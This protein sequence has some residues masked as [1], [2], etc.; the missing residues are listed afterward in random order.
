MSDKTPSAFSELFRSIK[1]AI[2]SKSGKYSL[3]TYLDIIGEF[4][5]RQIW[6]AKKSG[7]SYTGGECTV[8]ISDVNPENY[9]FQI[10]MFFR[11]KDGSAVKEEASREIPKSKFVS[12]TQEQITK[13]PLKFEI[14]ESEE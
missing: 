8:Q 5:D 6:E 7:R 2:E 9:L 13:N 4:T 3:E 12:E 11:D 1:F 10:E 14:L